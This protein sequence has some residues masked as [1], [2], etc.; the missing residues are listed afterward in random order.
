MQKIY[1]Y[2]DILMSGFNLSGLDGLIVL[3]IALMLIV[4]LVPTYFLFH[5]HVSIKYGVIR[6]KFSS[7]GASLVGSTFIGGTSFDGFNYNN[8]EYNYGDDVRGEV[9]VDGSSYQSSS[10]RLAC[11]RHCKTLITK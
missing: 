7:N 8:L 10:N 11:S 4:S 6:T 9:V 5:R 3:I 1:S 2:S